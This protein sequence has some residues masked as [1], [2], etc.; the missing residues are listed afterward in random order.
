[1]TVTSPLPHA[2][3]RAE[4]RPLLKLSVPLVIGLLSATLIGVVDTVMI[5]PLGTV[6]LAA[7]GITTAVLIIVI[8]ALWGL[9]TVIGVQIA[10]AEGAGDR[11]EVSAHVKSGLVLA[12]LAGGTGFALMMAVYPFLE[13]MGQPPEVLAILLPYWTSMALWIVPF[14]MFFVLKSLFDGVGREW[15]GVVLG[16]VGVLINVPANYL[17]IHV[18]GLGVLGAGL[19]S[20]LSQ[21]ISLAAGLAV[22]RFS[23]GMAPFRVPAPLSW[24]RVRTQLREGLP[25]CLGYAGEGGAYAFMGIMIG[26]LGATALAAHQVANAV[27]GL[28]Y[29][30]PLGMAGAVA[31]R[32]GQAI[33]GA[34]RE[35]L[36]P[37]LT[38]G[39][40]I[41]T[42][43]QCLVALTFLLAG[44]AIAASLSKDPAVVALAT[45]LFLVLALMQIAD[46][47]QSTALGALRGMMDN[48]V[49]TAITLVAYWPLALPAA[50]LI[51]MTYQQGAAGVWLGYTLGITVAAVALP[52]RFWRRTRTRQPL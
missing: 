46:G 4:I 8:S 27:A 52:W 39:L 32:V 19:A 48:R 21:T 25:L 1:M 43:W 50:Y 11:S 10:T 12:A 26:W 20:I 36:R 15:T 49:P 35:R 31:I 23:D 13:P 29:V 38:A 6:P 14:T 24:A 44:S 51:G 28:A 33:G 7:A 41:V 17:L 22:L 9:V 45:T 16:Y 18:S 30:I 2:T 5:A 37:I 40:L 34:R 42:V 3:A 47:V